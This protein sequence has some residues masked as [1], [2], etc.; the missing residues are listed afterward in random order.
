MQ[1]DSIEFV[2]IHNELINKGQV[3]YNPF[4]FTLRPIGYL[5]P[6]DFYFE[7][8]VDLVQFEKIIEEVE[9]NIANIRMAYEGEYDF[10]KA[11]YVD[12]S[13]TES[14]YQVTMDLLFVDFS[15][16][17]KVAEDFDIHPEDIYDLQSQMYIYEDYEDEDD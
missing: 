11:L 3:S 9:E 4:D 10:E 8:F 7:D 5:V 13:A 17:L 1:R 16:A 15:E 6:L 2:K 14:L 12:I